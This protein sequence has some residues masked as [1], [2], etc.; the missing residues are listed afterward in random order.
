[1]AN[2]AAH[3]VSAPVATL[4]SLVACSSPPHYSAPQSF[5]VDNDA[6]ARV[7]QDA[8]GGD[9][10]AAPIEGSPIVMCTGRTNCTINY[11]I[12]APTGTVFH[13]EVAADEQLFLPT[14]QMWKA[15]FT[16]PQFQRGTVTVRGPSL[17]N[18][19]TAIYFTLTCDR[20]DAA[21]IDWSSV[22]GHGIRTGCDYAPQ[23]QG[24]PDQASSSPTGR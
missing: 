17:S 18:S 11:T 19:E 12:R 5:T 10:T 13:K 9:R 21:K 20:N 15:L 7:V 14:A 3:K 2:R 16:D 22:D 6:V 4:A 8:L 23:V 1:M 24:L